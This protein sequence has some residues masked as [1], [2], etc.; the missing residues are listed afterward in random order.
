MEVR[1]DPMKGSTSFY[2]TEEEFRQYLMRTSYYTGLQKDLL[3][4]VPSDAKL[5]LDLGTGTGS[6]A[7]QIAGKCR[8]GI[9]YAT[10]IRPDI[11]H[12]AEGIAK[13]EKIANIRFAQADMNRLGDYLRTSR[14]QPDIITAVYSFHHVADPLENKQSVVNDMYAGLKKGGKVIIAD[15]YVDLDPNAPGYAKAAE[16]QYLMRSEEAY[17]SV[18]WAVL[19]EMLDA[20]KALEEALARA[21]QVAEFSKASELNALEGAIFRAKAKVPEHLITKQQIIQLFEKAGF[22]IILFNQIN[23]IGEAILL[24]ER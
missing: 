23:H 16:K 14:L 5:I 6:T 17:T 8:Q 3:A 22:R 9:V 4:L 24:A 21:R 11:L 18:F 12:L 1:I 10:D 19:R 15:L 20:G 2:S 7:M 13:R